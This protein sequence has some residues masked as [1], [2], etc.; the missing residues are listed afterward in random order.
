MMTELKQKKRCLNHINV[1]ILTIRHPLRIMEKLK[2]TQTNKQKNETKKTK[3]Q[4]KNKLIAR[5]R[6]KQI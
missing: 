1:V 4:A 6:E 5:N 3:L 2:H